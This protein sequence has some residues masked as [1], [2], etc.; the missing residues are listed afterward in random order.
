MYTQVLDPLAGSLYWS[1]FCA[2]L[3]LLTLFVL[4]G[5]FRVRAQI[6]AVAS[7]VLALALV[8]LRYVE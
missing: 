7:L 2:A 4:L 6:A 8:V 1:A 3:P 5:V